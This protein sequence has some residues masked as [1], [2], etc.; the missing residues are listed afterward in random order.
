MGSAMQI[1]VFSLN[2]QKIRECILWEYPWNG[3]IKYAHF[4][5]DIKGSSLLKK[6]IK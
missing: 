4:A 3:T 5:M 2:D 1:Q 6:S